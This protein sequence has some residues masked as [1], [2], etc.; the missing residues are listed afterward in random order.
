M[1]R[2]WQVTDAVAA[3]LEKAAS[4]PSACRD[5]AAAEAAEA[6]ADAAAC[7]ADDAM[8][9]LAGLDPKLLPDELPLGLAL[10]RAHAAAEARVKALGDALDQFVDALKAGDAA[11]ARE[12]ENTFVCEG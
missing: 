2:E 6:Q 11:G 1:T 4:M 8:Q 5:Y 9:E 7:A 12:I 10:H 3:L